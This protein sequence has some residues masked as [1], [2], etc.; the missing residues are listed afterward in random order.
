[1]ANYVEFNDDINSENRTVEDNILEVIE[2]LQY[3]VKYHQDN[4]HLLGNGLEVANAD[5][6]MY[7]IFSSVSM[8]YNK[9]NKINGKL[10]AIKQH[11]SNSKARA[12]NK[13]H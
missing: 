3:S 4:K 8:L 6:E 1:M 13:H 12:N 2:Y 9:V 5:A 11:N 7:K 10:M